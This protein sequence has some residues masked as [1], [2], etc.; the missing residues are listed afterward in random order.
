MAGITTRAAFKQDLDTLIRVLYTNEPG[1]QR[2]PIKQKKG[3]SL[4][5][6]NPRG[7]VL[8]A[9][10]EGQIVG[11]STGQL[12]VSTSEG[13]PSL[14]IEDVIV[15]PQWRNKGIGKKL[16]EAVCRWASTFEATSFQLLADA[17]DTSGIDFYK[18]T[19]WDTTNLICLSK[20]AVEV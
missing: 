3:L 8:V 2:N 14:L 19:G 4:M 15:A 5:L 18:N 10:F 9:E 20:A 16:V 11:M 13:G 12:L 17:A 1:Y 6:D 7:I